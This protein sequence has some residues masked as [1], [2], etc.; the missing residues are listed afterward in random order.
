MLDKLSV[1]ELAA[2]LEQNFEMLGH[3]TG[4]HRSLKAIFDE[5]YRLL[6]PK[7]QQ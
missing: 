6:T 2:N 1:E 3:G 4:R 7:Q 5:S